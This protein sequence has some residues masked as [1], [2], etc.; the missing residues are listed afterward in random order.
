MPL[1][2]WFETDLNEELKRLLEA[3]DSFVA[4]YGDRDAVNGLIVEH[5]AGIE[6]HHMVLWT[7]LACESWIQNRSDLVPSHA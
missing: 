3:S 5:E 1:K 6:D 4:V 7:I 2:D